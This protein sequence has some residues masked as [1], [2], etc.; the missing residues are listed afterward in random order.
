MCMI[1]EPSLIYEHAGFLVLNKPAGLI[2]H[3]DGRTQEY[4]VSQW[5]I[6]KYPSIAGVGES[7]TSDA[8]EVIE[9]PGIVHRLDRD[10][11]GVMVVAKTV[12]YFE[13]LKLLFQGRSMRKEY[14]AY[15]Y[16]HPTE[17][18]GTIDLPIGRSPRDPRRWSAQYGAKG[19]M[20]PAETQWRTLERGED[21]ATGEKVSYMHLSP[22]TGRTHQLRVHMKAIH[23]PIIADATYAE[24]R[25]PLLGFKRTALH[26]FKLCFTLA[27]GENAEFEAPLPADFIKAHSAMHSLRGA[28]WAKR[29]ESP[30]KKSSTK[31]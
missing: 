2:V 15:V 7:W 22:K 12:E 28:L 29:D 6:E 1:L 24:D 18:S 11:S 23:L 13:Y 19:Y 26:A 5:L 8:G 17:E 14:L 16:G 25:V 10:T 4:A 30:A 3:P 27:T 20:R 31:K 9:R 21:V